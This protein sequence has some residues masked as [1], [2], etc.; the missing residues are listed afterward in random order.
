MPKIVFRGKTYYSVYQM[1]PNVR[2]AYEKEREKAGIDKTEEKI[3]S[4][5]HL[6]SPTV[7]PD[8]RIGMRGLLWGILA[9]LVFAG[10][11]YLLSLFIP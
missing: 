8:A 7:E 11:A 9:A 1:P 3:D 4:A 2:L 10:I 5:N 6:S